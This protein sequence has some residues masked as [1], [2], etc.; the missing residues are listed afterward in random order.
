MDNPRVYQRM[1]Q[2]VGQKVSKYHITDQIVH[3]SVDQY[4][5][6]IEG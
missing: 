3:Q 2:N 4:K 1:D 5:D 6:Q